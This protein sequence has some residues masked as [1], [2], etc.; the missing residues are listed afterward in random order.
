MSSTFPT[1]FPRT[2]EAPESC[3]R[4]A[5]ETVNSASRAKSLQITPVAVFSHYVERKRFASLVI[6]NLMTKLCGSPIVNEPSGNCQTF[7]RIYSLP[8]HVLMTSLPANFT[9]SCRGKA[10]SCS[11]T[12]SKPRCVDPATWVNPAE[13]Q[14]V[15]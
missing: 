11:E 3:K 10:I 9:F 12:G 1:R 7:G 15:R 6:W 14:A 5:R 8:C 13:L 4:M 2:V